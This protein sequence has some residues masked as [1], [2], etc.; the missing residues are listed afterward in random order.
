MNK[1]AEEAMSGVITAEATAV[2]KY[3]AGERW[4]HIIGGGGD[5][6]GYYLG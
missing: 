4:L 2:T 6:E 1:A 5:G 3:K